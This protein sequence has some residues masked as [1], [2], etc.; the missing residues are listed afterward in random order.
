MSHA[1]VLTR[2]TRTHHQRPAPAATTLSTTALTPNRARR[3]VDND[4]YASFAR[5]VLRAYARRVATGDIDALSAMTDLSAE[6]DTAIGQAVTGLRSLRLLLGRHRHPARH[7]P[8]GRPAT[9]GQPLTTRRDRRSQPRTR[10]RARG[11]GRPPTTPP[12][13]HLGRLP[14]VGTPARHH[15]HVLPPHPADRP[16]RRHRPGHRRDRPGLRHRQR[17]RG[18]AARRV[19]QP[20]RVRLPGLLGHLQARRPAARPRG[21]GRRQGHPRDHHRAIRACSPPSPPPR[22]ARSTPGGCAARPCCPAAPAATHTPAAARTAATSP[23]RPGTS[24]TTPGSAS[25]CA[26]T[27][28][29][30]KPPSCST[31]TPGDLWRRFTTYLPRHLARLAGRHPEASSAPCCA[32]A[33]SRSPNTRPAASSTSTPSSASTPPARTTSHHPARYTAALLCDAIRQAAAAASPSPDRLGPAVLLRFGAAGHR[34]PAHPPRRRPA[35]HRPGAVRPGRGQLHRQVRHQDP[36]RPRPP[37]HA[38]SAPP[39]TSTACAAPATTSR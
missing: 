13:H 4:E 23:A 33:T 35:R 27:A 7:H 39:S 15:R 20:P 1:H 37:G 34:R 22:S 3:P 28:T 21:P 16:D 2:R 31:P 38:A 9:L 26:A 18:S 19:R 24:R 11:W 17:A 30:T 32:S 25:R 29:T 12:N 5:R 36:R 8:P 10:T 6:I 14:A